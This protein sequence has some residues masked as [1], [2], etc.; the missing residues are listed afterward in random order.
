MGDCKLYCIQVISI[1]SFPII[2]LFLMLLHYYWGIFLLLDEI[3]LPQF[4]WPE[5]S[6]MVQQPGIHLLQKCN[7]LLYRKE[8]WF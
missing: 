8:P 2:L 1:L 4:H 7:N 3:E 5:S 6:S